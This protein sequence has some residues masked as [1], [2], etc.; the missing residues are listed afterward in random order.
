MVGTVLV[1]EP[2]L[3]FSSRIESA[4]ARWG[5]ET[6]TAVTI[7]GLKEA[8]QGHEPRALVVNLDAFPRDESPLLESFHGRCRL[9]G[10]YSHTDAASA[11]R[12]VA[13]GFE[14]VLPRRT[15]KDRL[16]VILSNIGSS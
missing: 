2:D 12:A 4:A 8:L 16:N 14:E 6:K 7:E 13:I 9:I 10:Y 5:L 1:F 11:S 15:F 3:L